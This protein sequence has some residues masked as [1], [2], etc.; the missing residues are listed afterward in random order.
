M[1][2]PAS[3]NQSKSHILFHKMSPPLDFST[4]TLAYFGYG[5]MEIDVTHLQTTYKD[6]SLASSLID[7]SLELGR[8]RVFCTTTNYL[9]MGSTSL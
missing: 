5:G 1:N 3:P 6:G 7:Q 8:S 2:S 9:A 4:K